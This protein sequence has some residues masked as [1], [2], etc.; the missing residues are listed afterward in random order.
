DGGPKAGADPRGA[1]LH[2]QRQVPQDV[3]DG[4]ERRAALQ[5]EVPDGAPPWLLRWRRGGPRGRRG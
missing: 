3:R 1:A 4:R 2:L 5:G